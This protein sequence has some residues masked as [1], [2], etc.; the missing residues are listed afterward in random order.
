M[1]SRPKFSCG[2]RL[3]VRPAVEP[4]E[5]RR[6]LGDL[7]QDVAEVAERVVAQHLDLAAHAAG[8]LGRFG[9]H[10][11]R[12]LGGAS[13]ARHLA[14]AGREVVVPE[15]RHL[16]LERPLA[17]HHP[18][19]PPLPG[20]ED[21]RAARTAPPRVA[22]RTYPGCPIFVSTSSAICLVVEQAATA[23]AS[24]SARYV[25]DLVGPGAEAG[26]PQQMFDLTIKAGMAISRS[27]GAADGSPES[28][29][30]RVS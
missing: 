28:T 13:D 26:A 27:T 15:E 5:H 18:E 21:V 20:V 23:P 9:G 29:R 10:V 14:V 22:I 7:D 8:I 30:P 25:V 1:I 16:L 17:V 19:Q 4:D 6:V 24:D 11:A 2:L 3:R 12:G